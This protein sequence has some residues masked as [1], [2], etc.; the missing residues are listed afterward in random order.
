MN[1]KVFHF[2]STFGTVSHCLSE[3]LKIVCCESLINIL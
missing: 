1:K 3:T 2:P